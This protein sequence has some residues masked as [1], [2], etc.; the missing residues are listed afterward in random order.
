[1]S[2]KSNN[3]EKTGF[4][5]LS[6]SIFL[7]E[8]H[9]PAKGQL[10]I[11]ATW[12]GGTAKHIAKY[13]SIY[14]AIAPKARILLILGPLDGFL[15][16]Y[17]IQRRNIR[18][19]IEPIVQVLKE[20]EYSANTHDTSHGPT[21]SPTRPHI[22]LHMFSNGGASNILQLLRV[23]K[24]EIGSPLP[25]SG[26]VIDSALA[27]GGPKQ[28]YRGFQQSIPNGP[29]FRLFGPVAASYALLVLETSI[30][31]GR[32]P[33]PETAMRQ[34]IFDETLVRIG[35]PENLSCEEN[36][37]DGTKSAKTKRICYFASKA[38]QNTPFQDIISH[39][40]EARQNGWDVDLHLWDD[41]PHCNH[42]G[43]H[44]KEYVE[45]LRNIWTPDKRRSETKARSRL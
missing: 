13:T 19:A 37:D 34:C 40:E 42:V 36:T 45:A 31:L 10:V 29:I 5:A 8:P 35:G 28:N 24:S 33:R 14:K 7:Y 9:E 26:L 25:L 32:Y 12:L 17:P 3:T 21:H 18:P 41:T 6:R 2:K 16:P 11:L 1:M 38:D 30:A 43:K 15:S 39:S 22:L 27:V 20:C 23:W 4:R 44:E